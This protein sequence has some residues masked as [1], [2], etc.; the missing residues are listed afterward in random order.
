MHTPPK[1]SQIAE[2]KSFFA[3]HKKQFEDQVRKVKASKTGDSSAG[4][5]LL[6]KGTAKLDRGELFARFPPKPVAEKLIQRYFAS[7]NPAAR[8]SAFQRCFKDT[9]L[10]FTGILHQPTFWREAST[11]VRNISPQII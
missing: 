10:T 6:F 5:S 2:V 9:M 8:T 1:A 3:E 7:E 11:K 4:T